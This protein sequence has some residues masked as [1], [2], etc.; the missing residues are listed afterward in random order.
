MTDVATV[1][2]A[3]STVRDPE[4]DSPITE[5][6]FVSDVTLA[7]DGVHVRLR[8]PTYFCAPNFTYLMLDDARRA[9]EAVAGRGRVHLT[10]ED[11]FESVRLNAALATGR[12]FAETF[13]D[14]AAGELDEIRDRFRRKTFL[15]R[16][17]RLCRRLGD[18]D[19][20]TL[21]VGDLPSDAGDY[22]E[23]RAELGISCAPDAPF[24]VAADGTPVPRERL[25]RHRRAASVIELSY[26][27]NG[28]LCRRLLATRY[29]TQPE[30]GT[31]PKEGEAA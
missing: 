3:L 23:S 8:L 29:R 14:E 10:L 18:V 5:M 24:L 15:I 7:A 25:E 2:R 16:Q 11:H 6:G 20:P 17:E 19:L 30:N 27:G 4:V 21:T 13:G 22:L 28:T 1:H 31:R 9:V 12:S 26:S